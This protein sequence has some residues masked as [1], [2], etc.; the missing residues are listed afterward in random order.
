MPNTKEIT[1]SS[2]QIVLIR[3]LLSYND[4]E[5][6]LK[7]EDTFEKSNKII[8]AAVISIDGVTEDAYK[9]VRALPIA[10]YTAITKEVGAIVTGNFQP[11]K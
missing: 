6:A 10:D 8:E 2:G 11:A 5:A 1:T 4:L 9:K 3:S 7:I